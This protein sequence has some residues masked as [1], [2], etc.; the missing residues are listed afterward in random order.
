MHI[1]YNMRKNSF[2]LLL[3]SAIILQSCDFLFGSKDDSVVDEILDQGAIDPN[4][5]PSTVGYV[6]ILPFWNEVSNPVDVYIGYDEMMYVVDDF[7]LLIFDLKGTK[8][9]SIPFNG[10]TKVAQDRRLYTY[11]CARVNKMVN[12][13]IYN[14]PAVYVI[15]NAAGVGQAN[16]SDT[17]IH[18]FCDVSRTNTNFR[19]KT[20]ESVAFTGITFLH[21]NSFYVS[22]TGPTNNLLSVSAPDNAVLTFDAS[23]YNNS[24][25]SSLNPITSSLKSMLTIGGISSFLAPPQSLFAV[26][27]SADFLLLQN[28]PNAEYKVL[29]IKY[30]FY[31]ETGPEYSENTALLDFDTTK[32]NG[33]L[34]K[35]FRFA[36]P[37]DICVAPDETKY[38][39]VVDEEKDSVYQFTN[40]GFEG[41]NP[42]A[43]SGL[44]KQV[45]VS[46]GGKGA[47]VFQFNSPKGIAYFNRVLY[48]ADTKNNRICR[49]K[50]STDLE[51]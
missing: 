50:L 48:I 6:P 35:S 31:P 38:I 28:D 11:V 5:I 24:Y 51:R 25:A 34:Y 36:K 15:K 9:R 44:T 37:T 7:G 46:F 14:L 29:W 10:A 27:T 4:L 30:F 23:L 32:A 8:Q 12:G 17:L 21:D 1:K 43:S 16:I 40:K 47:G 41:V 20:D 18:P 3:L 22:R 26:E 19:G 42:P 33:F 13:A 2:Y 39:F 45:L 49:Y